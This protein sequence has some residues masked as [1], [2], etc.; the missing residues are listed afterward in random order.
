MDYAG[1]P[2]AMFQIPDGV[3]S[4][5]TEEQKSGEVHRNQRSDSQWPLPGAFGI[6]QTQPIL[7]WPYLR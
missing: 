4:P 3:A 6:L 5:N 7:L 1:T 2:A